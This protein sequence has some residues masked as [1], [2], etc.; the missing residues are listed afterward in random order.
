MKNLIQKIKAIFKIARLV[1]VDDSGN[2]QQGVFSYM[3]SNPKGQ[4]FVPYGILMNPPVG[5]QMAVFSQNGN[6]SNAIG[7]ASDPN[8]RTLKDLEPGEFGISNYLTGSYVLMKANGDIEISS[9]ADVKITKAV[10]I[11]VTASGIAT[12]TV[13][14]INITG[15]VTINGILVNNGITFDT[16]IH[17]Q[18]N[19]GDGD[20]EENT[21]GPMD[22]P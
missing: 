12:I 17:S 22:P 4:I 18:D 8:K 5:S 13:P 1:S 9:E 16:H 11:D 20:T 7:L 3:G 2:L 15:D 19:D 21:N 14:E 10:N 6:E